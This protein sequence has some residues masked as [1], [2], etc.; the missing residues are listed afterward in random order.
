MSEKIGEENGESSLLYLAW[1]AGTFL[2]ESHERTFWS[3]KLKMQHRWGRQGSQ[4]IYQ[5]SWDPKH[6]GEIYYDVWA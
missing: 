1:G 4:S 6:F 2:E 5:V 3:G